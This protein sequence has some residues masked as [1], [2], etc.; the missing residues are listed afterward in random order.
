M[1]TCWEYLHPS[2]PIYGHFYAERVLFQTEHV[3][4][5]NSIQRFVATQAKT[6]KITQH[7]QTALYFL[8]SSPVIS[9][10]V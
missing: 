9:N 1:A 8:S 10:T 2:K 5:R 4:E 7:D 3:P 6:V